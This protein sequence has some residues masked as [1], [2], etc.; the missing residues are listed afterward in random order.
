MSLTLGRVVRLAESSALPPKSRQL[1]LFGRV[2]DGEVTRAAERARQIIAD[3]EAAIAEQRLQLEKSLETT[4][5]QM[6]QQAQADAE[7]SLAAKAVEIAAL[8]WR[9]LV[10]ARNDIVELA[11]VMAERVIGETLH[12]N[13][14]RLVALA[15]RC[16]DEARGSS[17]IVLYAHP[18][19]AAELSQQLEDLNPTI[20][21]QVQ[22][23]PELQPGDLRVETDVGTVDA[24]IAT[25]LA[26]LAVKIR[27]SFRV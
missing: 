26:N 10:L 19:D 9:S 11:Q 15:Q 3:A 27:E 12:L 4:R 14:D 18:R 24:R 5:A 21:I 16:I 13:P 20:Q 22:P 7:V 2:V 6:L 8:R 1:R 17:R 25:Q 23:E